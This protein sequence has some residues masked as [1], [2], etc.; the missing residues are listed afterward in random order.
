MNRNIVIDDIWSLEISTH[1]IKLIETIESTHHKSI[2]E[3]VE[4]IRGYYAHIDE[5]L[6]SY[7]KK[8]ITPNFQ[9][10]EILEKIDYALDMV[11]KVKGK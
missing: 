3:K 5:A 7:I 11:K 10:F 6:R 2:G 1:D 4:R 8:S 9:V